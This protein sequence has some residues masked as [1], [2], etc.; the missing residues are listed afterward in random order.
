MIDNTADLAFC[1]PHIVLQLRHVLFGD[2]F[3]GERPGQHEFG[4]ERGA[5]GIHQAIQRCRHPFVD[6][7]LIRFCTSLT[8]WPVL[9]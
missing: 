3:L 6:W 8:T 1:D 7:M 9:R 5:I 4:L 2:G